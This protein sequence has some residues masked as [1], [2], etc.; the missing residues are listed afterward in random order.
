MRPFR[1]A[2]LLLAAVLLAAP[3][4]AYTIYL[5]DGSRLIARERY[6]I[7]DGKALIVL[8]NGTQTFIDAGEIDVE[9]TE[10]ANLGTYGTAL[11]LEEGRLVEAPVTTPEAPREN[12]TDLISREQG[13]QARPTAVRPVAPEAGVGAARTFGGRPDYASLPRSPH[14]D[15]EI[16]TELRRLFRA[17]GVEDLQILQ[18]TAE[19][20][21]LLEIIANSE[22]SVFRSLE[23][24][25]SAFVQLDRQYPGKVEGLELLLTTSARERAGQFLIGR[26]E[27]LQLAQKE[28]EPSAFYVRYVEF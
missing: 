3:L 25:A 13:V 6:V 4:A 10:R 15:L 14:R 9:R 20:H 17:Q 5:K 1:S 27:A 21:V 22:A 28:V 8:Q 11:V 16:S 19:T 12:L 26:A 2:L 18:G 24:A 23:T 7:E